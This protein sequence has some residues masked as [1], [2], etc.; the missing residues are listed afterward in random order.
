MINNIKY[1]IA[2][3]EAKKKTIP[4]YRVDKKRKIDGDIS[5]INKILT[6]KFLNARVEDDYYKKEKEENQFINDLNNYD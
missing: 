5:D 6:E 1:A 3:L 2:K 4:W